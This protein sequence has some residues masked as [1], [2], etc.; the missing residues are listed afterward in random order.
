MMKVEVWLPHVLISYFHND[1]LLL[2]H[3]PEKL[4]D[5]HVILT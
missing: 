2:L 1:M 3:L 4:Q 5:D